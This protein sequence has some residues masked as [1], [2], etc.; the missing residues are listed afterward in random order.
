[1]GAIEYI[2]TPPLEISPATLEAGTV[3]ARQKKV[4]SLCF[5]LRNY[6]QSIL[7]LE[8]PEGCALPTDS[9]MTNFPIQLKTWETREVR[10][11]FTPTKK[12]IY[13]DVIKVFCSNKSDP[14]CIRLKAIVK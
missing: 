7:R 12:G 11:I 4:L 5:K 2:G 10:L 1:M 9:T 6:N 14:I 13:S 8:L 3:K